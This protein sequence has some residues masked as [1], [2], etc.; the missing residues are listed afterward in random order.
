VCVHRISD[1]LRDEV[2]DAFSRSLTRCC[3]ASGRRSTGALSI[4]K[5]TPIVGGLGNSVGLV[6]V[7]PDGTVTQLPVNGTTSTTASRSTSAPAIQA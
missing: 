7:N 2:N 5:L 1:P 6:Y 3:T 4:G